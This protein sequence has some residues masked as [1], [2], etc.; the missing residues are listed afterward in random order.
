WGFRGTDHVAIDA[1]IAAR[2][3]NAPA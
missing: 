3:N 1:V 2:G